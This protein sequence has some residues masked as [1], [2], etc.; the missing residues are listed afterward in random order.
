MSKP[1]LEYREK[2][3]NPQWWWYFVYGPNAIRNLFLA[4]V[5]CVLMLFVFFVLNAMFGNW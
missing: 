1:V 5:G 3:P 4:G 2:E